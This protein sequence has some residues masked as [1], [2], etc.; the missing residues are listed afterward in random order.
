MG[1]PESDGICKKH[2]NLNQLP[3]VCSTCLR[4]RLAL[5][6][7]S[8]S[9]NRAL[10][11]SYYCSSS[12]SSSP[13][14]STASSSNHQSPNRR[15]IRNASDSSGAISIMFNNGLRKSRSIAIV[16]A[17]RARDAAAAAGKKKA[18]FWWK[19]F[20]S[21]GKRTMEVFTHSRSSIRDGFEK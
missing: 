3:G 19:L 20:R 1:I 15:H 2:P 9:Q 11:A 12:V 18:G 6:S 21:S 8:S 7:V 13:P 14:Y 4:E 16:P 10:V 5:L 17:G